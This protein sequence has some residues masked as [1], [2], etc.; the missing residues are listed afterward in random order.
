MI[1]YL[2][3]M[4]YYC[5]F[6]ILIIIIKCYHTKAMKNG[7]MVN[8]KLKVQLKCF[9]RRWDEAFYPEIRLA[10][11]WLEDLGFS[12]GNFVTINCEANRLIITVRDEAA[13]W[14]E[15]QANKNTIPCKPAFNGCKMKR[16]ISRSHKATKKGHKAP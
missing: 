5:N 10:G 4:N 6:I 12:Y 7:K 9:P 1:Y 3:K 14:A 15:K 13:I 11:K 2:Y 8:R 16:V